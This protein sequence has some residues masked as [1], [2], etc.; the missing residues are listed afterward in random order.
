MDCLQDFCFCY[1]LLQDK[2][3]VVLNVMEGK[4]V[5]VFSLVLWVRM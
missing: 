2:R 5:G 3:A 1:F 4:K